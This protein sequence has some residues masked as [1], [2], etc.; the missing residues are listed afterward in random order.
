MGPYSHDL[1]SKVV[2]AYV[3]GEGSHRELAA[4]FDLNKNT[5]RDWVQRNK[6]TGSFDAD[7]PR[8]GPEPKVNEVARQFL[9]E[10]L[11]ADNDMPQRILRERLKNHLGIEV[12]QPVISRTLHA[13]GWSRKKKT[14]HASEQDKP[15][16]Q[17]ARSD[18][19]KKAAQ[20]ETPHVLFF[21]EF[22]TNLGMTPAYAYAPV[23]ERAVNS[24]PSSY[25]ENV[26]LILGVGL[27]GVVAPIAFAGAMN[28]HLFA[29][30][31]T[32]QVAPTLRPGDVMVLDGLG[33]HRSA[34]ARQ[35]VEA[36]GAHLWI[37]PP[38]S[39]DM[40]PVE[41]SGSAIKTFLRNSEPRT[42]DE[43]VHAMGEVLRAISATDILGWFRDRAYYLFGS[44]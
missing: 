39:P 26:T 29:E 1:R 4:R 16:V 25:G 37:L 32:H 8:S 31:V 40:N 13:L 19:V 38:Y 18:F 21:D 5:V 3:R 23:G 30:Y 27:R 9:L 12:S 41:E 24:A 17:H 7:P 33:S 42:K 11:K 22:G 14:L 44:G 6:E 2:E 10:Q 28:A 20:V 35:A 36:R 43:L 15:E 34:I